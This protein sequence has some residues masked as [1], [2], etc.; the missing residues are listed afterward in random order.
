MILGVRNRTGA[1]SEC[2]RRSSRRRHSPPRGNV[3]Q[4]QQAFESFQR[5][6]NRERPHQALEYRVPSDLYVGSSRNYPARMPELAYPNG[7]HFR[8]IS[9]QGSLSG[10]ASAPFSVRCWRGKRS[11]SWKPTRICSRS[12]TVS[13]YWVGLTAFTTF[14]RRIKGAASGN[15]NPAK[16]TPSAVEMTRCGKPN[17]GF[18]LPTC[19]LM[20]FLPNQTQTQTCASMALGGRSPEQ[21]C[22]LCRRSKVLPMFP[23]IHWGVRMFP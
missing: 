9:Q 22:Y 19:C 10:K 6:Y 3:R 11:V 16:T 20:L 5:K 21:N 8:R 23:A 18:P 12:T 1:T 4:Q 14:S 2:I 17:P 13:Y 15:V 7:V